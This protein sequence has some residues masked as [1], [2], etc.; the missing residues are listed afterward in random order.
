MSKKEKVWVLTREINEYDQHGEYFSAVFK[1]R[2]TLEVLANYFKDKAGD[3]LFPRN[4]MDAVAF[5]EHL[6]AGGGRRGSEDIWFHLKEQ[7][8]R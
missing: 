5:L 8:L 3:E 7:V 6:R 2:P 1:E 4:V